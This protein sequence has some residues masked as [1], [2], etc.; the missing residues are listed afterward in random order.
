MDIWIHFFF[1]TSAIHGG[2]WWAS[3]PGRVTPSTHRIR[4]WLGPI[5]YTSIADSA[6]HAFPSP[7][8]AAW[9]GW[10]L[11]VDQPQH[12]AVFLEMQSAQFSLKSATSFSVITV[13]NRARHQYYPEPDESKQHPISPRCL[14]ISYYYPIYELRWT[15]LFKS[16]VA[17]QVKKLHVFYDTKDSLAR[18]QHRPL[19]LYPVHILTPYVLKINFNII[20]P[21]SIF[22]SK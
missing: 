4:S 18:S 21:I 19:N 22:H 2:E 11:T 8:G 12:P 1:F 6:L 9:R 14:L 13:K 5:P 20:S 10:Q 16:S 15:V 3:C 7:P 17:Q